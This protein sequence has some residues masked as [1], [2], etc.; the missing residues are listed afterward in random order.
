MADDN[1]FKQGAKGKKDQ[2][3]TLDDLTKSATEAFKMLA[4]AATVTTG[5]L[6]KLAALVPE[7]QEVHSL[8]VRAARKL[9]DIADAL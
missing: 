5:H 1:P 9:N 2:M 7:T 4:E 8:R 6:V 3:R